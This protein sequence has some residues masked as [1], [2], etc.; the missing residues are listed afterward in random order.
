M[1]PLRGS[2]AGTTLGTTVLVRLDGRGPAYQQI[3]RALRAMILAGEFGKESRLPATRALAHQLGVS[4]NIVLLAYRH[5]LHEGYA[6][7]KTG[8]GTYVAPE[9]P[10][11]I[12]QA[13]TRDRV[14]SQ[15]PATPRLSAFARRLAAPS[16]VQK[17][18]RD[19]AAP[20]DFRYGLPVADAFPFPLWRRLVAS[21]ARLASA[22]S[23]RYGGPEGYPPLREA[24]ADYLRRS[25][26]VDCHADQVVVTNGSQQA[27]DL[28]AR[29]LVDAGDRVVL[30]E[31]HYPGAREAFLGAG[32]RLIPVPVDGE[33]L[34]V[35]R[36]IRTHLGNAVEVSGSDAGL[37]LLM[38]IRGMRAGTS[39]DGL[40]KRAAGAGVGIYPIAPYYL[41]PPRQA[42]LFLGYAGL[43]ESRI[44]IG[45]ERL[46]TVL[47]GNQVTRRP[48]LRPARRA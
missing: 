44:R 4:R 26:A 33:G 14:T 20:Y 10:D 47:R 32:A 40:I 34:E 28:A 15:A 31:P 18:G 35:A 41:T 6:G 11:A 46:A 22:E 30:E 21:Q 5:L 2:A 25:R 8:S 7:G 39:L 29:V 13:P 24:I 37:H 16:L 3:Y 45:I 42:G 19:R 43:D 38:W 27:L 12:L 9:L 17:I 36:P 48:E 23:L 1:E